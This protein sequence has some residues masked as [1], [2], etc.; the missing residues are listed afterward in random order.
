MPKLSGKAPLTELRER[1]KNGNLCGL[2]LFTGDEIFNKEF[3][4]SR[5][6]AA[7]KDVPMAEFNVCTLDGS[8]LSE[9]ALIGAVE[10]YPVMA[11]NKLVIIK[12]SGIFKTAAYDKE[13]WTELFKNPPDYAA[14]IFDEAETDGRNALLKKFNENGLAV[15]FDYLDSATMAD[16]IA[17]YLSKRGFTVRR[18]AV[19]ELMSRAGVSMAD[20]HNEMEKLVDYCAGRG[21]ITA[22]DVRSVVP[23][24]LNDR[25]FDMIDGITAGNRDTAFAI[26]A[27]L[28]Q[29]REEP[30]KIVPL[31][32]NNITGILKAKI[33]LGG[34]STNLA[35]DL[36][37]APFIAKKYAA[38]SKRLSKE[39]L[40]NMLSL[41]L[42]ADKAIKLD[43][44][45]KWV[46]LETLMTRLS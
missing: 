28:K 20:V 25:I 15:T 7:F 33:L 32:G 38:Q 31:L 5:F 30:A 41:C 12:N 42:E 43:G 17:G 44:K 39:R 11:D 14:I 45:D 36:G 6:K 29:L 3:Y 46:V 23:R 26:L 10:S 16:W 24:S 9:D 22:D 4:I 2:Y 27:D 35:A 40:K 19:N 1:L 37:V 8:E 13:V 18:D 21:E 34:E